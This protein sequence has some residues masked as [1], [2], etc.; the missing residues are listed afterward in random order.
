MADKKIES[1]SQ[2]NVGDFVKCVDRDK[3]GKFSYTGEVTHVTVGKPTKIGR[4]TIQSGA[5]I[6]IVAMEGNMGFMLERPDDNDLYITTTKPTGWAKF[7]KDPNIGKAPTP[8][9]DIS[10]K[11]TKT[12]KQL[13]AELVSGNPRKN[14]KSLLKL[15]VAEIGGSEAQ[16]L[17]YIKLANLRK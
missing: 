17:N 11:D 16:L 9:P 2:V 8:A 3:N 13:V 12:K 15:A 10:L 5:L 6:E 14:E 4:E 1:V 7:K